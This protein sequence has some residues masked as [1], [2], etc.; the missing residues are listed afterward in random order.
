VKPNQTTKP[1]I[2]KKYK[3]KIA[4]YLKYLPHIRIN[5]IEAFAEKR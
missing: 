2:R 4:S 5:K 3:Y 1:I